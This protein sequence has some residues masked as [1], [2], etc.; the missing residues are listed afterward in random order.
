LAPNTIT[1]L[2]GVLF[3][4]IAVVGGG[5]TIERMQIP[6]VPRWSRIAA[7]V[8]GVAFLAGFLVSSLHSAQQEPGRAAADVAPTQ[9]TSSPTPG[10]TQTVELFRF[11]GPERSPDGLEL[12][13]FIATSSHSEPG[14]G[15]VITIRF[16]LRNSSPHPIRVSPF[17]AARSPSDANKDTGQSAPRALT[18]GENI[19][20]SASLVADQKGSWSFWPCY[21]LGS[22]ECPDEW[23]L[24]RVTVGD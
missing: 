2:A 3:L 9:T 19:P 23:Q 24:H 13:E 15:D 8:L 20:T 14:V 4:L 11:A 6:P 16:T 12:V 5:F 17:V 1:L 7:G 18:P 21:D 10:G 22:R